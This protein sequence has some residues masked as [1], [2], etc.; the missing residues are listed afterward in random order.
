MKKLFAILILLCSLNLIGFSQASLEGKTRILFIYD[1]SNSMN[2]KWE[3]GYKHQVAKKLLS[4]ALDSLSTTDVELALRV[5]G[6]QSSLRNGQDCNDTKLE[7]P[8]ARGNALKI[9]SRLQDV[10]PKGTT[11]IALTLEKSAND[12]RGC[13]NC[14]NIIVLI[15]DG[16]EECDGDPCAVSRAL[17]AKGIVLKPFVIGIGLDDQFKS[18]FKCIGN[19]FD[20]TDELVFKN[21]LNIVISQ[22]LNNTSVQVNLLDNSNKPTETN[23]NMSFINTVSKKSDYNYI[24]TLDGRG[25]PDT[26]FIDPSSSYDLHVSTI[27]SLIKRNVKLTPGQHN[28]IALDAAQGK[29]IV[30]QGGKKF[31]LPDVIIRKQDS[32]RTLHVMDVNEHEKLL[33]GKYDLEVLTLPRTYIN[34]VEVAQSHTTEVQIPPSGM[35]NINTSAPGYGSIFLM[36]GNQMVWVTNLNEKLRTQ[37]IELQPGRYKAVF[38]PAV[39]L[40]TKFT[41]EKEFTIKSGGSTQVKL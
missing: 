14:K 8:F 11:P 21:V 38:R 3:S 27:P 35:L 18:T 33:I 5:Y 6:H 36:E 9:K 31:D 17:Q 25:L 2:G 34:D 39:S 19:Y 24:H 23:V 32:I 12:F 7:V 26:L 15:T 41:R 30:R 4:Q 40:D 10:R 28:I 20:A 16:I 37:S 22:A 13:R 29:L 1:A